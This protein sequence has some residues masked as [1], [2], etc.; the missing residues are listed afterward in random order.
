MNILASLGSKLEAK[1]TTLFENFLK[2]RRYLKNITAST[3]QYYRQAW[4]SYQAKIG[5]EISK[6]KAV[7]FVI[8]L[9]ESGVSPIGCNTYISALNSYFK[10]LHENKHTPEQVKIPKIKTDKPI[11]QTVALPSLEK[12]YAF[13]GR[14]FGEK[15]IH[16]VLCLIMDTGIRIKCEALSIRRGDIDF[17]NLLLKIV[18]KGRKQRII[19]FSP[20]CR[21]VLYRWLKE[22]KYDLVFPARDGT[23]MD[24]RNA[25][26]DYE[27]LCSKLKIEKTGGF[28]RLRHTFALQYV[29]SGGGLFHLQKQLGH[30]TLEMT[31]RYTELEVEDLQKE[32]VKTSLLGRLK[33]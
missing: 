15:R 26:R 4:K 5:D 13:K 2:E 29:R 28:H 20:E 27:L 23:T 17:D 12:I 16:A 24:Y 11:L 31:R 1:M 32:H 10:W 22:H 6:E 3:E 14:T 8:A 9:R 21:K 33:G 25:L 30:S 7:A 19:P 18:G